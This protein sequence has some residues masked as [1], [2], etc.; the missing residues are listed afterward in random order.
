MP[1]YFVGESKRALSP[2]FSPCAWGAVA[3]GNVHYLCINEHGVL[4]ERNLIIENEL[5]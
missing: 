2:W 5:E 4:I 3:P 1:R